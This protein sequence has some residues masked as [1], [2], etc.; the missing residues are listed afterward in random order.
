MR[1]KQDGDGLISDVEFL[2]SV[3]ANE[4]VLNAFAGKDEL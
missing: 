2:D 4:K 1:G 3:E